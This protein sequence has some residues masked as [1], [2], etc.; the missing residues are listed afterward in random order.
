MF[1]LEGRSMDD[2]VREFFAL[3]V[4]IYAEADKNDDQK[5]RQANINE[6]IDVFVAWLLSHK[7]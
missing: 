7:K 5:K 6:R 1:S 4:S 3:A 2:I